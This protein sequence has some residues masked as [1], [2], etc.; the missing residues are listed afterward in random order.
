MK[1]GKEKEND[2]VEIG[3]NF[4]YDIIEKDLADGKYKEVC[5]RYPPEP[6]GY[7]HIG[8]AKAILI[9]YSA[10]KKYGGKFNLRYDDT[11]PV[12]EDEEFVKAIYKDI[13][14]LIGTE[15]DE[16][17]YGSD[18][19][20]K[21]YEYAIKLIKDGKAYV[22]DLTTEEMRE[23]RGNFTTPGKNS[24]YRDRT[25]EENLDLFE[26]MKN[27]EFPEKSKT[28]R[29]KIDMSHPN[30]H[31][32]D[33]AIY[34]ILYAEHYRQGNK[35]CIYPMYD[36][37]HPMQDAIEGITHSMCSL[38]FDNNR[39]VYDW[40]VDN[41]GIEEDKKPHQ[42]EFAKIKITYTIMGKRSLIKMVE[43]KIVDGWDDPRLPTLTAL[44]R[45]GFTP[46][47]IQ[48]F[49]VKSGVSKVYNNVDIKLL[50]FCQRDELN[51]T[52]RRRIAILE[53]VPVVITNYPE[54]KKEYFNISNNPEDEATGKREV[55]FSK[56]LYIDKSDFEE[57]PPPKFFRLTPGGEVRLMGSYIIKCEEI[58]KN[59][60]GSI[61]EI[62]CTYDPATGGKNPPDGRKIKG[63]IHWL[64]KNNADKVNIHLYD[65]LFTEEDM[66]DIPEDK[67]YTDYINPDSKIEY[68]D[69]LL[70]KGTLELDERF[71]FVRMGYFYKDSKYPNTYNRIVTLK[72]SYKP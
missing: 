40:Y 12:K 38:E 53:P 15:P 4:L 65:Y 58:I 44:R 14:W 41:V 27:G 20:E 49:I 35:W 2:I 69:C 31:M 56:Y 19:F 13:V 64:S 11:N 67:S 18:Y 10:K 36:Y 55:E 24:P 52:A 61:K 8:H 7:L 57:N 29:A 46:S 25:V 3:S 62:R 59:D 16:V 23:Y 71:Q 33:P 9:N 37:A 26:R 51:K 42:Y 28:L 70:E 60:D 21:C 47:A 66:A 50:D 54:D 17:C 5:T 22:C 68:I 43:S 32:R 39:I 6:N 34:R 48:N 72:D 1:N 45:R 63:T 30:M